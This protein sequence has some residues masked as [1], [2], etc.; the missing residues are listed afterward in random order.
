MLQSTAS[1]WY[2]VSHLEVKV[3]SHLARQR[4]LVYTNIQPVLLA[5]A[6][7]IVVHSVFSIGTTHGTFWFVGATLLVGVVRNEG[8][9]LVVTLGTHVVEVDEKHRTSAFQRP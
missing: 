3:E 4:Y 8:K 5:S 7:L 9:I 2:P 1:V 6:P